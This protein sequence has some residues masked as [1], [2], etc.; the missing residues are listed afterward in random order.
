MTKWSG[1]VRAAR[2]RRALATQAAVLLLTLAA[3]GGHGSS[4]SA[5]RQPTTA[6]PTTPASASPAA[7]AAYDPRRDAAADITAA[8][9]AAKADGHP[10][11][12]DF[13]ADW[14]PDCQVLGRTLARPATA[15]LLTGYHVVR[16]DVGEFDHN[17]A[18]AERYLDLDTSGIPALVVLDPNGSVKVATDQGQ[19][20]NAR[21]MPESQV[22]AFLMKWA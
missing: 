1:A 22:D 3:C 5:S 21:S 6:P 12:I 11:L 18:I 19:F 8:Q 13:G 17:I 15:K 20:E 2:T 9:R 4:A 7:V 10:V 14:C 16:V